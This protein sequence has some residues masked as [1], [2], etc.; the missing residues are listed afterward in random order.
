MIDEDMGER[1]KVALRNI[2][3]WFSRQVSYSQFLPSKEDLEC[4]EAK[5]LSKK[6]SLNIL[7]LSKMKELVCPW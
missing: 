6:L 7:K 5:E 4:N 1:L 2:R 3:W